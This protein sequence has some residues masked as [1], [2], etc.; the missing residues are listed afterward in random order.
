MTVSLETTEETAIVS[1]ADDGPGIP[2]ERKTKV[3][4]RGED[5]ESGVGLYLTGFVIELYGGDVRIDDNDPKG[6]V[7][8]VELPRSTE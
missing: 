3:F 6:S 7:F 8:R 5:G 2:D 4:E 1:V